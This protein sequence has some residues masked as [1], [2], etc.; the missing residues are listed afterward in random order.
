M[1][2]AREGLRCKK[3]NRRRR[4]RRRRRKNSQAHSL[5]QTSVIPWRGSLEPGRTPQAWSR[6]SPERGARLIIYATNRG[7]VVVPR[8][9]CPRSPGRISVTP[10]R[11]PLYAGELSWLGRLFLRL[12]RQRR[13][14]KD[15]WQVRTRAARPMK[16]RRCR[17]SPSLSLSLSLS[18][19]RVLTPEKPK[20]KK[21]RT[22]RR[23]ANGLLPGVEGKKRRRKE[24]EERMN[25]VHLAPSRSPRPAH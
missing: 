15:A 7:P 2:A 8:P 22:S 12:A 13:L 14:E 24:K 18:L 25:K 16:R 21:K 9:F 20:N 5:K 1:K 17:R 19:V 4:R 6:M 10:F 3:R 11:G 23:P